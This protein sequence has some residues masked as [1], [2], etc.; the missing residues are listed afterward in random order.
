MDELPKIN[1]SNFMISAVLM[2]V[3][4]YT[5]G[6]IVD[7][8]LFPKYIEG[9][10]KH[11]IIVELLLQLGVIVVM[12]YYSNIIIMSIIA[13]NIKLTYRSMNASSLLFPFMMYFPMKNFKKRVEYVTKL[14]M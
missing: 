4:A 3:F 2:S 10:N 5:L 13:R 8:V 1:I 7:N 9:D 12:K 11:K 6:N 14:L